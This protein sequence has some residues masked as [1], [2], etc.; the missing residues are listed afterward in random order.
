M[1]KRKYEAKLK[2]VRK[3]L[4]EL[5]EKAPIS[6]ELNNFEIPSEL[7]QINQINHSKEEKPKKRTVILERR[8]NGFWHN[9]LFLYFWLTIIAFS[10][11][12]LFIFLLILLYLPEIKELFNLIIEGI[13]LFNA[14]KQNIINFIE[15]NFTKWINIIVICVEKK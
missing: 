3:K 6:E 1:N 2:K 12:G 9:F 10:L 11:T 7:P 15:S 13:D 14:N 4:D 5:K 8:I